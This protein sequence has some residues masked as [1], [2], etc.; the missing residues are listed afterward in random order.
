M[1]D[2]SKTGVVNNFLFESLD[3]FDEIQNGMGGEGTQRDPGEFLLIFPTGRGEINEFHYLLFISII[4]PTRSFV[5]T[6]LEKTSIFFLSLSRRLIGFLPC[7]LLREAFL[8]PRSEC[9]SPFF[10]R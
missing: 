4:L 2:I 5:Q 9:K 6:I 10:K 7:A 3:I 1:R 8:S